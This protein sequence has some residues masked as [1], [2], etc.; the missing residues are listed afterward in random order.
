MAATEASAVKQTM[1]KTARRQLIPHDIGYVLLTGGGGCRSDLPVENQCGHRDK[2]AII[3][4]LLQAGF[5]RSS[6]IVQAKA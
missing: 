5:E 1:L 3:E 4:E 6:I 2:R